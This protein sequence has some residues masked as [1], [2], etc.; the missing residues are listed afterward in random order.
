MGTIIS[1]SDAEALIPAEE[2]E[3][4]IKGI[5]QKSV[6]LSAFTKLPNMSTNQAKMAVMSVLPIAYWNA[7]DNSRKQVTSAAWASKYIYAEEIAVIVP[8]SENVLNDSAYDIWGE[9]K[10]KLVEA[11]ANKIDDAMLFGVDKPSTWPLDIKSACNANGYAVNQASGATFYDTVLTAMDKVEN[12]GF[13][14]TGIIG[15]P[16]LAGKF[17]R[18][19][20]STGQL[21]TGTDLQGLPRYAV[22]NGAFDVSKYQ[23]IVGDLKQAVYSIRQ[24]ITFKVLDQA[25]IQ[26]PS[27]GTILYNLAQNDMVALRATMRIGYQLPNPVNRVQTAEAARYPFAIVGVDGEFD[28][29]TP[30]LAG[31]TPFASTTSVTMTCATYGAK[32]YYTDDGTTPDATKTLYSGAVTLSATKTIKAIAILAGYSNSAVASATYTKS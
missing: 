10:D 18:L 24:D 30:V 31:T 28:V 19:V 29:A 12:G 23:C 5:T 16:N 21:L 6:A 17:R 9:V 14:V 15:G 26:D 7:S 27:D 3:G 1:R 22:K 13:D 20:D 32:I 11:F 8:I 25:V 4:I 2:V